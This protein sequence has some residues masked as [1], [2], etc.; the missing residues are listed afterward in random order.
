MQKEIRDADG[1]KFRRNY[2]LD[3]HNSLLFTCKDLTWSL[4][5]WLWNFFLRLFYK[6]YVLQCKPKHTHIHARTHTHTHPTPRICRPTMCN[7][8]WERLFSSIYYIKVDFTA[9]LRIWLMCVRPQSRPSLWDPMDCSPQAPLSMGF[10]RQEYW[11][12]LP[13]PPSEDVPDPMVESKSLVSP[14]LAGE[15]FSTEL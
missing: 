10:S 11:S 5:P 7:V 9:F 12:G 14:A 6:M 3:L 8:L 2:M 13:L 1:E 15:L 4:G